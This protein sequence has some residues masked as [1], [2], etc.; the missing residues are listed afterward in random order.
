MKILYFDIVGGIAGDM[1]VAALLGLGVPWEHLESGLAGLGLEGLSIATEQGRRHSIA[2]TRFVVSYPGQPELAAMRNDSH[3]HDPAHDHGGGHGGTH[4]HAHDHGH[5]GAHGHGHRSESGHEHRAYRDIRKMIEES[6]LPS[7]AR[8]H[9]LAIFAKLA[10]A[11]GAVH[12][13]PADEV[14]FH[15]VGAWDS[16]A[17]VVCAAL[18]VDYLSP[19]AVYCSAVPVG[20]GTVETAHGRMPIPTPA[21]LLLLRGF[22]ILQGGPAYERTTPTGAAILAA[23]ARPAPEPFAFTPERVGVGIGSYDGPEVPNLLRAVLGSDGSPAP[24]RERIECAEA[25][26]DDAN[27][28]WIGYLLERLL[29]AGA[30]DVALVPIQM[31]KNR[32]GTQI[33]VLYPP[34]LREAV[35]GLLF[36]EATTLG[37]RYHAL[38]RAV[39]E[40]EEV[41]VATPWGEVAGK[42][43]HWQGRARF[44]P[45]FESCRALALKAQVPLREVYRAAQL[46]FDQAEQP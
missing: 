17:D 5:G 11:E 29:S 35:L 44:S 3:S 32:P 13:V 33:Q 38:E 2:G 15:E 20:A 14:T 1:T 30:L 23:L 21:T 26:L 27:P 6:A 19:E 16:I 40:R 41:R 34:D 45:E 31:K 9:A 43:A 46:A 37:V 7:G 12:G 24:G 4:G 28:E 36:G 25:N 42:V 18:A 10:E 8:G 39:L 22:P